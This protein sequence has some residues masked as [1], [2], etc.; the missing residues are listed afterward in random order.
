MYSFHPVSGRLLTAADQRSQARVVVVEQNIA[1][2][3]NTHLGQR[4]QL[5][6]AA[7]RLA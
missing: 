6:T 5:S 7:L 2:T 1:R 3:T 4:V